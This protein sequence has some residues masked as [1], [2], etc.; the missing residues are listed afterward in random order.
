MKNILK[1]KNQIILGSIVL[2]VLIVSLIVL[3]KLDTD[4]MRNYGIYNVKYKVYQNG[5]WTKNSKNGMTVGDKKNPIQNI[6][7]SVKQKFGRINY[8]TYTND[9]SDQMFESSRENYN[10]IYGL[11][12][13]L[14]N[15]LYKKYSICYRTYNKKDEW[16]N[17]ACDGEISGNKEEPITA[18][19][20]KI[21]PKG[22][23][24]FDYLKD[25]NKKIITSNNF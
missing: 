21:I 20:I 16:L 25:Y 19:E 24:K 3:S 4:G 14:T 2:L 13:N 23:L 12:F 17:W 10:Q 15:T 8:Y 7:I 18:L 22:G 11:K 1:Y 9:W 6:S 5:K